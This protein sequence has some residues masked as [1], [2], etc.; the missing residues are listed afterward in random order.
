MTFD[1][2]HDLE[3]KFVSSI[4]QKRKSGSHQRN[5]PKLCGSRMAHS[6]WICSQM[7]EQFGRGHQLWSI[8]QRWLFSLQIGRNRCSKFVH[9][10]R[11]IWTPGYVTGLF[12]LKYVLVTSF[13]KE[14]FFTM[15]HSRPR[16]TQQGYYHEQYVRWRRSVAT[17]GLTGAKQLDTFRT[18]FLSQDHRRRNSTTGQSEVRTNWLFESL[19]TIQ[20]WS[21]LWNRKLQK[22]RLN[23]LKSVDGKDRLLEHLRKELPQCKISWDWFLVLCASQV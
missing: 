11:W 14:L 4:N 8:A 6:K 18:G 1:W 9:H 15:V 2:S 16:L 5:R 7:E 12:L 3:T 13:T 17:D 22:L 19:Q 10:G 23:N 20:L 21:L